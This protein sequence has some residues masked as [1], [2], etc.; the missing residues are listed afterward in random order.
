MSKAK[1]ETRRD[2][3]SKQAVARAQATPTPGKPGA[4]AARTTGTAVMEPPASTPAAA[5]T[6]NTVA[7]TA[8][9]NNFAG[10]EKSACNE[11]AVGLQLAAHSETAAP[12][13]NA[14]ASHIKE[15]IMDRK[16]TLVPGT[17][18]G[19]V[20]V[21]K[22]E[23]SLATVRINRRLFAGSAPAE[24]T[25]SGDGMAEPKQPKRKLT[26][27]ERAALPKP[28]P[29]QLADR[30]AESAKRAVARAQKLAEKAAAAPKA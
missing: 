19:N 25:L 8:P 9:E 12:G 5:T 23:G 7:N 11:T 24:M 22:V 16:L 10:T 15:T 30:A 3:L 18:K 29:Q 17:R 27:E 13:T 1:R 14:T 28:T 4:P 26:K 2:K 21:Y 20:E 6:V